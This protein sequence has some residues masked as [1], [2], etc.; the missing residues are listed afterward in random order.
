MREKERE[1]MPINLSRPEHTRTWGSSEALSCDSREC[2]LPVVVET[3]KLKE[4]KT[5]S[6]TER[7]RETF[8]L[9]KASLKVLERLHFRCVNL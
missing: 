1:R 6:G 2:E 4:I 7:E 3:Q 5:E 8:T 9:L